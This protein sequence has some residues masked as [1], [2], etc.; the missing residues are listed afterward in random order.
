MRSLLL[1]AVI[2]E[3]VLS[4]GGIVYA[5][6]T[7]NNIA[8]PGGVVRLVAMAT[9]G[10]LAARKQTRWAVWTFVTLEYLTAFVALGLGLRAGE[11]GSIVL[12]IF[13]VFF[14]LGTAAW[15]GGREL[16]PQL[17]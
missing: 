10:F 5:G 6:L 11:V 15:V 7:G 4:L 16:R 3:V 9:L 14:S 12:V 2:G 17:A 13:A 8:V 1:L